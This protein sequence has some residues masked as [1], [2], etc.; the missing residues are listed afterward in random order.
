MVK[1]AKASG[2]EARARK[3]AA[4]LKANLAKR[5][6]PAKTGIKSDSTVKQ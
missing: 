2:K 6:K 5:K 3:L 1:V 4:A